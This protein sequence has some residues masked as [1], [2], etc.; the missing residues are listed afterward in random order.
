MLANVCSL[1]CCR[2]SVDRVLTQVGVDRFDHDAVIFP[3]PF[4]GDVLVFDV[5]E[6]RLGIA[7]QW[8]AEAT[9]ARGGSH[10]LVAF[11][12][13]DVREHRP[14]L[15][16]LVPPGEGHAVGDAWKAAVDPPRDRPRSVG[17]VGDDAVFTLEQS[18]TFA[19]ATAAAELAGAAGV[20]D[21]RVL[22]REQRRVS[23]L[24]LQRLDGEPGTEDGC[25]RVRAV[26]AV[27]TTPATGH[28]VVPHELLTVSAGSVVST[29]G[30]Q[31][32]EV[33]RTGHRPL[34]EDFGP[35]FE[36][37]VHDLLVGTRDGARRWSRIRDPSRVVRD[38]FGPVVEAG[39]RR[40]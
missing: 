33:E 30:E 20:S 36:D 35:E 25:G 38:G 24:A 40:S 9:T 19:D 34:G 11:V 1:L 12:D 4:D 23:F 31:I 37:G 15:R 14:H 7:I 17:A 22:A 10:E 3:R 29:A 5:L 26:F 16:R 13:R 8:V 2:L 27:A 39:R 21:D 28:P 6:D 18:A 32:L